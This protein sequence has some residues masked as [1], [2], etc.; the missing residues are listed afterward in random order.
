MRPADCERSLVV[1][2]PGAALADALALETQAGPGT[3]ADARA[4]AGRGREG[5]GI[6]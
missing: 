1:R 5:A 3:L 6:G 4:G 2:L